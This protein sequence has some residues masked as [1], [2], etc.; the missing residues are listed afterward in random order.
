MVAEIPGGRQIGR[1][2]VFV[3]AVAGNG[4]CRGEGFFE[5]GLISYIVPI[6]GAIFSRE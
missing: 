4:F 6:Y 5:R 2:A 1:S 3:A